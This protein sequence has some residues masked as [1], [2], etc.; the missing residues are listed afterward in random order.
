[1]TGF[2]IDNRNSFSNIMVA[3]GMIIS[4]GTMEQEDSA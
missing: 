1:M 4:V 3:V 2:Q